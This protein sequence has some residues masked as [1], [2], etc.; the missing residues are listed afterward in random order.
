[1]TPPADILE[2]VKP[3]YYILFFVRFLKVR[4][5]AQQMT[6]PGNTGDYASE[7]SVANSKSRDILKDQD[8][9]IN[10]EK[11]YNSCLLSKLDP[12]SSLS[13]NLIAAPGVIA[14]KPNYIRSFIHI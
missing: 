3:E 4:V 14:H 9:N 6:N 5:R 1:M 10:I 8:F 13:L 7:A 2:R 12:G 11:R